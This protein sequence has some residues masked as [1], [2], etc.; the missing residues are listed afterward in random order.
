[1][2]LNQDQQS[3]LTSRRPELDGLRGVAIL[4]IVFHHYVNGPLKPA[5][6]SVLYYLMMPARLAWTGVDLFFV[7]SGYLVGG[8]LIANRAS[9]AFFRT[10]YVRRAC[11]IL[12]LYVTILIL[13]YLLDGPVWDVP[14]PPLPLYLT[15]TQNFWMAAAGNFGVMT[16]AVTWSLAIEEQF[17][18]TVPFVVRHVDAR[19]L[20]W[21]IVGCMVAAPILRFVLFLTLD[22][23]YFASHVLFFTRMDTLM[24]GVFI[25]WLQRRGATIPK[26]VLYGAWAA[27]NL[28]MLFLAWKE[29]SSNVLIRIFCY[30]VF[31]VYYGVTLLLIL[32]GEFRFLRVKPLAYLGVISYGM[33]LLH[34]PLNRL[35]H[36]GVVGLSGLGDVAIT[37]TALGVVLVLASLCWELLEKRFIT[38]GHRQRY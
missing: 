3:N 5:S 13:F 16:L 36:R 29:R 9:P 28:A 20:G 22:N 14:R 37:L 21:V 24:V 7:L 32:Q 6:G 12:P 17:Y 8:I 31:A 18:L 2:P 19:R 11:R 27:L 1:M 35:M 30:D 38:L 33:Y 25:A 15:F 23:G 26:S 4:L 34:Q 10:F